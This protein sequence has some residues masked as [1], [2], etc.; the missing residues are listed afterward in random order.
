MIYQ[1]GSCWHGSDRCTFSSRF[2]VCLLLL[3]FPSTAPL[4]DRVENE[5][6]DNYDAIEYDDK[7]VRHLCDKLVDELAGLRKKKAD[8]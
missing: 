7:S 3:S 6:E 4:G 1:S 5:V 8:E 2:T